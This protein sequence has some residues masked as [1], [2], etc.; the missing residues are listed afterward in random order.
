M[1]SKS[2][3]HYETLADLIKN[4][5]T[6]IDDLSAATK[7]VSMNASITGARSFLKLQQSG[8]KAGM[9][10]VTKMY[11]YTEK[12]LRKTLKDGEWLPHEGQEVVDEWA[13][14]MKAGIHEFKRVTDKSFSLL[15][16][17]LDRIEKESKEKASKRKTQE[18]QKITPVDTQKTVKTKKT[19]AKPRRTPPTRKAKSE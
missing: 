18:Q 14:T 16:E 10:L 6:A 4:P 5:L 17:F 9:E 8:F 3:A 7:S 12:K 15:L 1:T 11:D 2:K 13:K 19:K